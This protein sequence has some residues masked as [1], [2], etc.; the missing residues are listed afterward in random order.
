[1]GR[2]LLCSFAGVGVGFAA[3]VWQDT[4]RDRAEFRKKQRAK[5]AR[6]PDEEM[7]SC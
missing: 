6:R 1:M 4:P 5:L 2:T 3:G 7:G